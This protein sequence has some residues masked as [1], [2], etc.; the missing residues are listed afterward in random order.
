MQLSSVD[1]NLLL[2][3][4]A[5]LQEGSVHSAARRLAL[6]ASATS[7]ALSRLRDVFKDPLFVRVGRRLE[8]TARA[9][10]LAPRVRAAV[11]Q[12]RRVFSEAEAFNPSEARRQ[13]QVMAAD[14][15]EVVLLG[16]ALDALRAQAPAITMQTR[17]LSTQP[18]LA[19]R[20]G[21]VDLAVGI[22]GSVPNEFGTTPLLE[23][24][25][26][27]MVRR[28]HPVLRQKWTLRSYLELEHL[29]VA[30][31]FTAGGVLDELL[32]RKGEA[33]RVV[34]TAYSFLAGAFAVAESDLALTTSLRLADAAR[35]RLPL[36]LLPVPVPFEPYTLFA[37][38]HR[39]FDQ[40]P[41]HTY[42]RDTLTRSAASL[43]PLQ[44]LRP[45]APVS[46][47]GSRTGSTRGPRGRG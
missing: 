42:F 43:P 39:R 5:L 20:S 35:R 31:T 28:N 46:G 24:G 34:R 30:P 23:D 44:T 27:V 6:S 8:P 10:Q 4:D 22:F 37:V 9:R 25:P 18:L 1:L 36:T 15:L 7:H 2:A 17:T 38:W 26:V 13:L 11:D 32:A 19:L 16:R 40:D 21:E 45:G 14:H 29:V 33:R 12:L 47:A 41:L 3:L